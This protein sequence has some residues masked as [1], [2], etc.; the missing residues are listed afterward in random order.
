MSFWRINRGKSSIV[1]RHVLCNVWQEMEKGFEKAVITA[2]KALSV[3]LPAFSESPLRAFFASAFYPSAQR[4]RHQVA[5][6]WD[7]WSLVFSWLYPN[8]FLKSSYPLSV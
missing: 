4:Q 7:T 8:F 6:W 5:V 1:P 2:Y 3:P